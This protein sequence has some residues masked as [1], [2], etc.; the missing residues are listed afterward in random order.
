MIFLSS[1]YSF[2]GLILGDLFV[3]GKVIRRPQYTDMRPQ[4][5]RNRPRPRYDRR[6]ETMQVQRREG[7]QRQNMAH[8]QGAPAQQPTSMDSQNSASGG[9]RDHRLVNQGEFVR[10][11]S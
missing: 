1:T 11:N 3:D 2:L 10:N 6:R 8:D 5:S 7:M 9:R 4:T